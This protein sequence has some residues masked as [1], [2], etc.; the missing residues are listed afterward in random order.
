MK[1]HNQ[2]NSCMLC[3][4]FSCSSIGFH[5]IIRKERVI[6]VFSLA[7]SYLTISHFKNILSVE[8][9]ISRIMIQIDGWPWKCVNTPL[10]KVQLYLKIKFFFIRYLL[11]FLYIKTLV[12]F[13]LELNTITLI[14]C[15]VLY[16]L[17]KELQPY[18]T[19]VLNLNV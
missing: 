18:N 14:V 1:Y 17:E 7:L 2:T 5:N 19:Y 6:G 4:A 8:A 13:C 12:S 15:S 3:I 16:T 10:S 9:I 11:L